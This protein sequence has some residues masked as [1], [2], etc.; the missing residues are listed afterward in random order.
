MHL[1]PLSYPEQ[2]SKDG[3]CHSLKTLLCRRSERTRCSELVAPLLSLLRNRQQWLTW[4]SSILGFNFVLCFPDVYPLGPQFYLTSY[5]CEI[6]RLTRH[7]RVPC[8]QY[9]MATSSFMECYPWT[10]MA[11]G[12]SPSCTLVSSGGVW[13]GFIEGS[14]LKTPSE[15][16]AFHACQRPSV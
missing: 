8:L 4:A 10:A 3:W 11:A 2:G 1:I 9:R 13:L 5:R 6:F 7:R 15:D 16:S 12:L 14:C